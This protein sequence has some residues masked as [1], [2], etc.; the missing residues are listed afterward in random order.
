MTTLIQQPIQALIASIMEYTSVNSSTGTGSS[1][2]SSESNNSNSD[3]NSDNEI[4]QNLILYIGDHVS[5]IILLIFLMYMTAFRRE[6]SCNSDYSYDYDHDNDDKNNLDVDDDHNCKNNVDDNDNGNDLDG[7]I[8][9]IKQLSSS[10]PLLLELT[11]DLQIQCL[12]YLHPRDI[13]SFGCCNKLSRF[14]I[15]NYKPRGMEGGIESEMNINFNS[16]SDTLWLKLWYRDYAWILYEWNI[17]KEAMKRSLQNIMDSSRGK[18]HIATSVPVSAYTSTSKYSSMHLSSSYAPR[19]FLSALPSAI[20]SDEMTK[21]QIVNATCT[22]EHEYARIYAYAQAQTKTQTDTN[23]YQHHAH[24]TS[25]KEFYLT[26][27]QTWLNYTIAGHSTFQSCL[28]GI[29]G[30]VFNITNFLNIH[31]GS[32]ESLILQGGGRDSTSFFESVGHSFSARKRAVRELVEVVDLGCCSGEGDVGL[33]DF[34]GTSSG[35]GNSS[36]NSSGNGMSTGTGNEKPQRKNSR[37]NSM[38]I[39]NYNNQSQTPWSQVGLRSTPKD[40]VS[41][42]PKNRSRPTRA[43]GTLHRIKQKLKNSEE[44]AKRIARIV[45]KKNGNCKSSVANDGGSGMM[46]GGVNVY[47]D[48]FDGK[49]H[50]WYLDCDFEPV[51]VHNFHQY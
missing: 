42:I 2:F 35:N 36:G 1:T 40:D 8:H 45:K 49:W 46:V 37:S 32:P 16:F 33:H 3:S 44:V 17:G 21:E 50:G 28:T 22:Q 6:I 7:T 20:F 25:M 30:H 19:V 13:I 47:F 4:V 27:S 38:E 34:D 26:F 14:L 39:N 51:F 5:E 15:D 41:L 9:Y 29:H 31:P 10:S 43:M 11:P 23:K 24:N 18:L 48:P 12:T